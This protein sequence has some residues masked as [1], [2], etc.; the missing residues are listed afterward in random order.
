MFSTLFKKKVSEDKIADYFIHNTIEA[1]DN[2]FEDLCGIIESDSTFVSRPDMKSQGPDKML[3]MV[4]AANIEVIPNYFESYK[5]RRITNSCYKTLANIFDLPE[6]EVQVLIS[7]TQK[8]LKAINKP[9]KNTLYS[10]S[11]GVFYKYRLN[12]CQEP[13]FRNMKNPNPILL[14]RLDEIMSRFLWDWSEI[15]DRYNITKG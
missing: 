6:R 4:L 11:K 7:N 15:T 12:D 2:S 13:Y 14:K 8:F 9:S 3:I 10:M 1:V 5:D